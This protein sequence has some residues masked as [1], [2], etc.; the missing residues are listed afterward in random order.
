MDKAILLEVV[1]FVEFTSDPAV[2]VGFVRPVACEGFSVRLLFAPRLMNHLNHIRHH[3]ILINVQARQTNSLN[4]CSYVGILSA[5]QTI[6]VEG[7]IIVDAIDS[8]GFRTRIVGKVLSPSLTEIGE[9]VTTSDEVRIRRLREFT[10]VVL[11]QQVTVVEIRADF[12][13]EFDC[14]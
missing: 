3:I 4:P 5:V 13:Y 6:G 11:T 12:V 9:S 7:H 1:D 10:N 2:V 8:D 14:G